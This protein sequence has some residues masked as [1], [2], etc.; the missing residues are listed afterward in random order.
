[1]CFSRRAAKVATLLAV[2]G[3]VVTVVRC[4]RGVEVWHV[5]AE[6]DEGP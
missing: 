3:V 1:M 6:C 4:R 2:I 5:A